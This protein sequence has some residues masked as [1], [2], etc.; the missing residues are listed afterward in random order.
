MKTVTNKTKEQKHAE[1]KRK[2]K[3]SSFKSD[4]DFVKNAGLWQNENVNAE[5][6]RELAWKRN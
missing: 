2:Y 5:K 1:L 4:A 6:L 3:K